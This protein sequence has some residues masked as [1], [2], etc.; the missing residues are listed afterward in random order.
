MKPELLAIVQCLLPLPPLLS[1]YYYF[2]FIFGKNNWESLGFIA[3]WHKCRHLEIFHK[4]E[5]LLPTQPYN[6]HHKVSSDS[7]LTRKSGNP[8]AKWW[9]KI[10]GITEQSWHIVP[11]TPVL[12][13]S[14]PSGSEAVSA[15]WIPRP[16]GLVLVD[17][18]WIQPSNCLS[19]QQTCTTEHKGEVTE[20]VW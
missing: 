7:N 14:R 15:W 1:P 4:M 8:Y 13:G 16:R 6:Q 17:F 2:Y 5:F 20:Q 11:Q 12:W 9:A 3:L 18:L 19:K 10:H